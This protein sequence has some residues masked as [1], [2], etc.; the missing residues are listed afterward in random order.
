MAQKKLMA[1]QHTEFGRLAWLPQTATR[2]QSPANRHT[3]I[4][5]RVRA[6]SSAIQ[7]G[8]VGIIDPCDVP[9]HANLHCLIGAF[10]LP[11]M[12]DWSILSAWHRHSVT[13]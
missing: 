9:R 6:V 2:H 13:L 10:Y 8:E 11:G 3:P 4:C 12:L 5:L 1:E 7:S